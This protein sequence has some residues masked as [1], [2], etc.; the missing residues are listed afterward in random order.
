MIHQ[1]D[2]LNVNQQQQ[3]DMLGLLRQSRDAALIGKVITY[4]R[5][6]T[7]SRDMEVAEKNAN[8]KP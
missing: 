2:T 5:I 1:L 8:H 4:R 6:N 3:C 7:L